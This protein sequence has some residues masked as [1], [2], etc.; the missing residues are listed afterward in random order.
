[1]VGDVS[2]Y[3]AHVKGLV[4]DIASR[5]YALTTMVSLPAPVRV[6]KN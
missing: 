3:N 6:G 2:L 5:V 4:I 1:M